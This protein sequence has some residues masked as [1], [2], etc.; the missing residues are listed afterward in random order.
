MQDATQPR[1]R[2]IRGIVATAVTAGLVESAS[3]QETRPSG[4]IRCVR[5]FGTTGDGKTDDTAALQRALDH[6]GMILLPGGTYCFTTLRATRPLI[7]QGEGAR[8]AILRKTSPDSEGIIVQSPQVHL[9]DLG[10]TAGVEQTGGCYLRWREEVWEVSLTNFTMEGAFIGVRNAAAYRTQ[11]EQ[12]SIR[13]SA[14]GAGS[15]CIVIDGG[16]DH[17]IRCVTADNPKQH[18]PESGIRIEQT[19]CIN[20]TDVDIIDCGRD[21]RLRPSGSGGGVFSVFAVNSF[22]DTATCGLSVECEKGYNVA[23]CLFTNCWFCSH[24]DR[25]I[26]ISGEGTVDTLSF[27]NCYIMF[28][29]KGGVDLGAGTNVALQDSTISACGPFGV[30]VACSDSRITGN[31]IGSTPAHGMEGHDTGILAAGG[32][33]NLISQNHLRGNKRAIGGAPGEHSKVD[34]GLT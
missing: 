29:A 24:T 15:A 25:G 14:G 2:F 9:R 26:A 6:G 22:F 7:L 10:F 19:G 23:R 5:D 13:N 33:W 4:D 11:I 28:N 34:A 30:R 1:R 8:S 32:D 27:V 17:F 3:G 20:L 12:G 16:N 21:L 31:K 18:M